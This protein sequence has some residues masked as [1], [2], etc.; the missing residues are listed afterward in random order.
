MRFI[1]LFAI[2]G[3]VH[4]SYDD[5]AFITEEFP[6]VVD[7]IADLKVAGDGAWDLYSVQHGNV[8]V[9]IKEPGDTA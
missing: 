9:V 2:G 6:E 1:R 5:E 3:H 8:I 7:R 4:F